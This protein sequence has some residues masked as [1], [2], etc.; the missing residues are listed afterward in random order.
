MIGSWVASRSS[1]QLDLCPAIWTAHREAIDIPQWNSLPT[2]AVTRL[3]NDLK[4]ESTSS[5]TFSS[6]WDASWRARSNLQ[7]YYMAVTRQW[8]TKLTILA[9]WHA[10]IDYDSNACTAQIWATLAPQFDTQ[11]TWRESLPSTQDDPI[12]LL[13]H[14]HVQPF[15]LPDEKSFL[16][17]IKQLTVNPRAFLCDLCW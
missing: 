16:W 3:I 12:W 5:L 2:A 15:L 9:S 10:V 14:V 6:L 1:E 7:R 17:L 4:D 8:W 11:S 13:F